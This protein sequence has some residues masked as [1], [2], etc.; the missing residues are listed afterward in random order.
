MCWSHTLSASF[1]L[2]IPRDFFRFLSL[3]LFPRRRGA[4]LLCSF[5]S[6][7]SLISFPCALIF[8]AFYLIFFFLEWKDKSV[9]PAY[10]RGEKSSL[11]NFSHPSNWDV[12]SFW[13]FFSLV[14][15]NSVFFYFSYSLQVF[16]PFL[17]FFS[18]GHF[19]RGFFFSDFSPFARVRVSKSVVGEL[20]ANALETTKIY[21]GPCCNALSSVILLV[22]VLRTL[23]N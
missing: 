14:S 20:P 4:F 11:G 3:F 10:L 22:K 12:N 21:C 15:S 23:R 1:F 8:F 18:S 9:S 17:L 13:N 6:L 5:S 19:P 2:S 16:V 7:I